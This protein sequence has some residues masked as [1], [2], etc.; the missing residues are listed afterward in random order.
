MV[1]PHPALTGDPS[2]AGR[3]DRVERVAEMMRRGA[4]IHRRLAPAPCLT[5]VVG[6]DQAALRVAGVQ[7][8]RNGFRGEATI[9]ERARKRSTGTHDARHLAE[10]RHRLHEIVDRYT[11]HR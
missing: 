4:L 9:R 8:T 5:E 11:T 10:H 1:H 3:P 2:G 6:D 7:P